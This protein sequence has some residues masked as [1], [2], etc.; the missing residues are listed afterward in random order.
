MHR[1]ADGSVWQQLLQATAGIVRGCRGEQVHMAVNH[2]RHDELAGRI[3]HVD[4]SPT[5][6]YGRG[7]ADCR[8]PIVLDADDAVL[9]DLT[10]DRIEDGTANDVQESHR[11]LLACVPAPFQN[12]LTP[13][14][15]PNWGRGGIKN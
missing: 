12:P 9:Y 6:G 4:V 1:T 7:S 8:N 5:R 3:E 13:T 11:H 10:V 15:A 2:P 14:L